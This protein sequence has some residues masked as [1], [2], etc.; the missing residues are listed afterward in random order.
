MSQHNGTCANNVH[1]SFLSNDRVINTNDFSIANIE[2]VRAKSH[3][4]RE[5]IEPDCSIKCNKFI[6]ASGWKSFKPG[7]G[8][9][10]DSI[11]FSNENKFKQ[12]IAFE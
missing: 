9:K 2:I 8:K 11:R 12:A 3:W 1:Y 4:P 10:S 7:I 5:F 6:S